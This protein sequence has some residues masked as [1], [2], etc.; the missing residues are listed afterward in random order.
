M[1]AAIQKRGRGRRDCRW[2]LTYRT[3]TETGPLLP[4]RRLLHII[5]KT[6]LVVVVPSN[7]YNMSTII[8]LPYT[9]CVVGTYRTH[10]DYMDGARPAKSRSIA[11][12]IVRTL[13]CSWS[14]DVCDEEEK[15]RVFILFW[16]HFS[17]E[18]HT[19]FHCAYMY[20]IQESV[21]I[22]DKT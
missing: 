14:G 20:Y 16:N 11:P 12:S 2:R 18:Q 6:V 1:F 3:H 13:R 19:T 9:R 17:C 8:T 21:R 7:N 22:L 15:G 4:P 5:I 10:M